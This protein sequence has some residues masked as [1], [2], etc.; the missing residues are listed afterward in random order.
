[1]DQSATALLCAKI[2][3]PMRNARWVNSPGWQVY[4]LS[5]KITE[6]LIDEVLGRTVGRRISTDILFCKMIWAMKI[7]NQNFVNDLFRHLVCS[8]NW[9]VWDSLV[10][11]VFPKETSLVK[12]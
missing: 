4:A 11:K 12:V 7:E 3:L 5:Y 10:F 2:K 9:Y 1:M 6:D 8:T